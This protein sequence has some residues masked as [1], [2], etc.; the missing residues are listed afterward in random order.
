[1]TSS[2]ASRSGFRKA[3]KDQ[4]Y[5]HKLLPKSAVFKVNTLCSGFL[6]AEE[7]LDD[8]ANAALNPN[9]TAI[10]DGHKI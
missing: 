9:R 1:M 2:T 10:V 5:N 8:K 4:N 7:N 3:K 6:T